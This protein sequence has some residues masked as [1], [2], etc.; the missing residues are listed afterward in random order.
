MSYIRRLRVRGRGRQSARGWRVVAW[1]LVAARIGVQSVGV[2]VAPLA[3][4][5][6][7][8]D[9]TPVMVV[10]WS[11]VTPAKS[12]ESAPRRRA[13][14]PTEFENRLIRHLKPSPTF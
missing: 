14:T 8:Q 1:E 2:L 4:V 11:C 7:R 9:G 3:G 13:T 10:A 6:C 12:D 5:E